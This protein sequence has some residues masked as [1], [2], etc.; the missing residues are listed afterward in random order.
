MKVNSA[1]L[2]VAAS[3]TYTD[4]DEPLR[5]GQKPIAYSDGE[6]V[7]F[8]QLV[9]QNDGQTF[10]ATVAQGF[11][12]TQL[13]PGA[14]FNCVFGV[15]FEPVGRNAVKTKWKLLDVKAPAADKASSTPA[16]T[17]VAA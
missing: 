15:T 2:L 6:L 10:R 12:H 9:D 8:V 5:Q 17:P 4:P 1:P 14:T 3:G 13:T 7:R 16:R 11:D